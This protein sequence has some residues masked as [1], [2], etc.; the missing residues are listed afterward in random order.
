M[1]IVYLSGWAV[2]MECNNVNISSRYPRAARRLKVLL[3]ATFFFLCIG[4]ISPI[5][6]LKKFILVENT[7]SVLSGVIQLLMEGHIF[8]FVV[9][10]SFSI[11]TPLLKIGVLFNLLSVRVNDTARLTKCLYWM[12][13]F[14]K[15]SMLDV[16]VVAI[17]VVAVKLGVIVSVD[18]RFGLYSFAIAVILTMYI[19]AKVDRLAVTAIDSIK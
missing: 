18:M 3:V 5:I 7:F 19:T 8:L 2:N 11:I 4:L 13:L 9:I 1:L 12:H 10:T 16:F 6:T 14:G 15:W 17:L